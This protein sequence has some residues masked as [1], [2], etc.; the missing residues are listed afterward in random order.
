[1]CQNIYLLF[2]GGGGGGVEGV[3]GLV[4][5]FKTCRLCID[6]GFFP[7]V[8][9]SAAIFLITDDYFQI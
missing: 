9:E 2:L 7:M 3:G 5:P 4:T 8:F 6:P 1:M